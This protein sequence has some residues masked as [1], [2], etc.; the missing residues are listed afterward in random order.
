MESI[1]LEMRI[2]NLRTKIKAC[3]Q[4]CTELAKKSTAPHLSPEE[5]AAIIRIKEETIRQCDYHRFMLDLYEHQGQ[6]NTKQCIN[7]G[8][9]RTESS[10]C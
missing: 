6:G 3:Q 2:G 7:K 1:L 4:E 5:R 8:L 9:R 10:F